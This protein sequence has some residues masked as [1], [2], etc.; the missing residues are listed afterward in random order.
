MSA[1]DRAEGR[2]S[3]LTTGQPQPAMRA[4]LQRIADRLH[5]QY[6]PPP[7][8]ERT[9]TTGAAPSPRVVQPS[10]L[11]VPHASTPPLAEQRG[12]GT[13]PL[14]GKAFRDA[15]K[16]AT[17]KL[18]KRQRTGRAGPR[19]KPVVGVRAAQRP[20]GEQR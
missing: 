12:E 8:P 13:Q 19:E 6:E 5:A 10:P 11:P 1:E 7:P 17:S 14:R 9:T 4:K 18:H 15:W 20:R 2:P 3:G 16:A